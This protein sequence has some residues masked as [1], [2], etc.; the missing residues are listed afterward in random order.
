MHFGDPCHE[1]Y[2]FASQAQ[3]PRSLLSED[4]DSVVN[5]NLANSLP[6][7]LNTGQQWYAPRQP[8]DG[9]F[10][11]AYQ[12]NTR[13]AY[14]AHQIPTFDE[15]WTNAI[16]DTGKDV[17][18]DIA[19]ALH[20]SPPAQSA[21]L[22]VSSNR[23]MSTISRQLSQFSCRHCDKKFNLKATDVIANMRARLTDYGM[24]I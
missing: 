21:T 11:F 22:P 19:R 1:K 10:L 9:L 17:F 20:H 18:R 23:A 13:S 15:W 14:P 6:S 16:R 24:F 7:P 2:Y 12:T 8:S 4:E 5:G 3:I